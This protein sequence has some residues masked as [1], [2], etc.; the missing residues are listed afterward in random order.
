MGL[1]AW[2]CRPHEP[3]LWSVRPGLSPREPYPRSP[4]AGPCS[5]PLSPDRL[6]SPVGPGRGVTSPSHTHLRR[7][8]RPSLA[9]SAAACPEDL[10][11]PRAAPLGT[12]TSSQIGAG[13]TA[14]AG[15]ACQS[16]G[17][18]GVSQYGGGKV[19]QGCALGRFGRRQMS[20][21]GQNG[22][23]LRPDPP[24]LAPAHKQGVA[25]HLTVAQQMANPTLSR[26]C[27]SAQGSVWLLCC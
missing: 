16:T 15:P 18:D 8:Q 3:V 1:C 21:T 5:R 13:R 14:R 12:P 10:F 17:F 4:V 19:A 27:H 25:P 24:P 7:R 6:A 9:F 22:W 2:A 11:L 26:K 23:A 20:R